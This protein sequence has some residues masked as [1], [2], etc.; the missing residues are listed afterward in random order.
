M[1][2]NA[3]NSA[4]ASPDNQGNTASNPVNFRKLTY[5]FHLHWCQSLLGSKK[6]I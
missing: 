3:A 5:V 2:V 6:R 1:T 4:P